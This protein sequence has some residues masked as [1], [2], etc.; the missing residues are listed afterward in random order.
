[1]DFLTVF[2]PEGRVPKEGCLDWI[3]QDPVQ[4]PNSY[5]YRQLVAAGALVVAEADPP[6]PAKQTDQVSAETSSSTRSRSSRGSTS[7]SDPTP[8]PGAAAADQ[9]SNQASSEV[10]P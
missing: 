6:A 8:D 7:A 1:M 10:Q 3:Q 4:V 5:Y 9:T 2:A